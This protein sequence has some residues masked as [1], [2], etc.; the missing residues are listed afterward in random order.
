[1]DL[2]RLYS[3]FFEIDC[4]FLISC[5]LLV[6]IAGVIVFRDDLSLRTKDALQVDSDSSGN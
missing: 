1:M 6:A 4:F 5:V 3:Y 2:E